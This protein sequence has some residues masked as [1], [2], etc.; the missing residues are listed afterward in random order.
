MVIFGIISV[1]THNIIHIGRR[2][3]EAIYSINE[4]KAEYVTH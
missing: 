3:N 1:I 4:Q 2:R